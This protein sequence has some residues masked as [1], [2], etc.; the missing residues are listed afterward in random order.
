MNKTI[1]RYRSTSDKSITPSQETAQSIFVVSTSLKIGAV[2]KDNVGMVGTH[3]M[4]K[5]N[6]LQV[7][8]NSN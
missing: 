4:Y 7:L 6:Y 2:K 5:N 8:W 1:V 3:L